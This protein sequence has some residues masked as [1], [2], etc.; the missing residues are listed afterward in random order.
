M[1]VYNVDG[2]DQK[3]PQ[4]NQCFFPASVYPQLS[5]ITSNYNVVLRE[6]L[7]IKNKDPKM[8]HEWIES[9][10]VIPLYFFGKWCRRSVEMCP[11]IYKLVKD[12]SGIKTVSVSCLRPES[13]LQPHIGWGDLANNILRCHFGVDVPDNCG[14]VCDNWVV[15]HRNGQW[16]IFDD[17][18]MHSAFNFGERNRYILL[19]DMERPSHIPKGTCTVAYSQDLLDMISSFYDESDIRDIRTELKV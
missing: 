13:C 8:W 7:S 6:V 17:S 14:C 11:E 5:V 2:H 3:Y 18:K 10:K 15:P 19:I 16:L 4:F 12:I 9:L 1:Q